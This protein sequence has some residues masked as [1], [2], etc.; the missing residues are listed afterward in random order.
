VSGESGLTS[1]ELRRALA[2]LH[3]KEDG[4]TLDGFVADHA[5]LAAASGSPCAEPAWPT[6]RRASSAPPTPAA[7]RSPRSGPE[8]LPRTKRHPGAGLGRWHAGCLAACP[9]R[10]GSSLRVHGR[11]KHT[12]AGPP[13]AGMHHTDGEPRREELAFRGRALQSRRS[14]SV[15]EN[16]PASTIVASAC[17]S[18]LLPKA[19]LLSSSTTVLSPSW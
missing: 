11:Y 7:P 10:A 6:P 14:S 12:V 1:L 18:A 9:D 13:W 16:T 2:Y 19:P 15:G 4:S 5:P 17:P 8:S 3:D